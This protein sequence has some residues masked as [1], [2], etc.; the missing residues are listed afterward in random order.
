MNVILEPVLDNTRQN[1]TLPS[2]IIQIDLIEKKNTFPSD[3]SAYPED[4]AFA[5]VFLSQLDDKDF[6]LL[7]KQFLAY[8]NKISEST[9]IEGIEGVFDYEAV[10]R[11]G[12][13]YAYNDVLP[14]GNQMRVTINDREYLIFDQFCLL[15]GCSCTH[16]VLDILPDTEAETRPETSFVLKLIYTKKR[17]EKNDDLPGSITL[18]A[19]RSAIEERYPDFYR[20]LRSRHEKLKHIYQKCRKNEF[21]PAQPAQTVKVG[22]NDPCP[23][24]SGKK[25]KKCCF[26]QTSSGKTE[27]NPPN[28]MTRKTSDIISKEKSDSGFWQKLIRNEWGNR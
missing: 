18:A 21:L 23:C 26:V 4:S 14:Y 25:Y 1:S 12:L 16:T 9:E 28:Q 15:P 11:D 22:R 20:S 3:R 7:D 17:W 19:V 2:R 5:D 8:K 6:T 24:G 27:K 10:E 13:M